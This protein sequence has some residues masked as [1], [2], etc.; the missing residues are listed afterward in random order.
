MFKASSKSK[1][2]KTI[3]YCFEIS[4]LV[5]GVLLFILAIYNASVSSN[6][7]AFLNGFVS[8][9]VSTLTIF[10]LGKIC[11]LL[12]CKKEENSSG[13]EAPGAPPF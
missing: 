4:A 10:G 12:Y 2:G 9:I 11:D 6:F 7:M 3:F 5:V 8:M 13:N 1:I